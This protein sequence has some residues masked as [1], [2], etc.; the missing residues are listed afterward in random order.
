MSRLARWCFSHR[1][2]VVPGWLLAM[3]TVLTLSQGLGP[4]FN[5]SFGLPHTDSQAAVDLL[6]KN[7][8]AASG[9]SDQIVIEATNGSTIS[10]LPVRSAVTAA[11]AR[12]AEVPGV[13]TVN[14]PYSPAGTTQISRDGTIAFATVIWDKQ[15]TAVTKTDAH[16]LIAAA[17]TADGPHVHVSLGGPSIS[18]SETSGTGL[19]VGVGIIAALVILLIVFGGALLSSLMP[20]VT[21]GVALLIGTSFIGLLS[22][23]FTVPSVAT[24][25]AVLIGLGVGVD[26]GLFII[27]RHRSAVKSGLSYQDAAAQAVNTSG[28]TVVF[29]GLTVCVALLGQLALGVSFLNGLSVASAIAVALTMATSLTFLPAMLGFLG[30]KVLSRRERATL[31]VNGPVTADTSGMW[32]RWARRIHAN[33]VAAA[34]GSI[35][36]VA[37]VASP[38]FGLRLGSSDAGTDPRPSTTHQAYRTLARGF[39]PG[40]NG[41]LELAAQLRSPSDAVAFDR[42]VATASHLPGVASV[43]RVTTS[44]NG[45]AALAIV[46]PATSPQSAQTSHLVNQ[47]RNQ[48]IPAAERGHSLAVHVGGATATNIDFSHVLSQKLPLFIAVVVILAFLL[49]TVVFRS[50]L[51]PLVASTMNLLSVGAALG[52]LNAVFNWGWGSSLLGLSGTGPIDAWLPVL[53][54]S[55]LFGLSMDYEVYL[56]SRIHE[57]WQHRRN[58]YSPDERFAPRRLNAVNSLAVTVGQANSG[59]V[60]AGAAGIMILVFGSFMLGGMRQMAEFGFGL[61]FAVL[62]DALVIRMMAVP[63]IMHLAGR[64][65]WWVPRFLDRRLPRVAIETDNRP[66]TPILDDQQP[67]ARS[68]RSD[69]SLTLSSRRLPS[70]SG[71]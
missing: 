58:R 46:Y 42:L 4:S 22:H 39:G 63:A 56:V 45:R 10:S 15:A 13:E 2:L 71:R 14:S 27:S 16:R 24:D 28:R 25:M 59:R 21:A 30:P 70:G 37:L 35:A 69:T 3:M 20:L 5:A 9:E 64:A 48:V 60:I 41:P 49:L 52:A 33:K 53:L 6:E 8:P 55:V 66:A 61:A 38:I 62:V 31:L 47:L 29:A 18:N 17:D 26:Y 67:V 12:V 7:F 40:F 54:F 23:L 43:S 50:L 19:S 51:V 65:N 1:K 36:V 34:V 44:P 68:Q 57:E 32:S 11:L